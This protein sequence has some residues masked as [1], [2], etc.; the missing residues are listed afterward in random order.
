[1]PSWQHLLAG[2]ISGAIAPCVN[3]PIDI[4]KTRIQRQITPTGGSGFSQIRLVVSSVYRSE[5]LMGFYSGLTPR[6]FR[7]APG[8]AITFMI[9]EKIQKFI[10]NYS[11]RYSSSFVTMVAA[12]E[13]SAVEGKLE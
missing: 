7:I 2:G 9:Y 12:E 1:M 10:E 3:A 6:L 5:G 11:L 13:A 4:V 8:Q